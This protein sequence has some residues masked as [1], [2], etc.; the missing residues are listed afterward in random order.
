M[1]KHVSRL[2]PLLLASA[3]GIGCLSHPLSARSTHDETRALRA[4]GS[5][6]LENTNGRVELDTWE[7]EEVRVHAELRASSERRLEEIE[8]RIEGEGDRVSVETRLPRSL[9]FGGGAEVAYQVT[10]P[11]SAR[12]EIGSVNGRLTLVGVA[13]A[14]KA[15]TVNGRVELEGSPTE[16]DASTVNGRIEARYDTSAGSGR[17]RFTTTNGRVTLCLPGDVTGRFEAST[18]NGRVRSDLP[19]EVEGRQHKRIR[20][21]IGQGGGDYELETVNG[22]VRICRL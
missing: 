8:V 1:R 14:V 18:V 20:D 16:V 3:L 12:V 5:F 21:R 11:R 6:E 13:G 15:S 10:V 17:H 7:R 2:V 9:F 4:G 22:S 19:L